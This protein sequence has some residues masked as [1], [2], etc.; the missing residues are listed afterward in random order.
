MTSVSVPELHLHNLYHTY[1]LASTSA[2][3]MAAGTALQA[4][5]MEQ[6]AVESAFRRL[7]ELS[8]PGD[9][10]KQKAVRRLREKPENPACEKPTHMAL[11]KSCAVKF[12]AGSGFAMQFQ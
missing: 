2:E 9:V 1:R 4:Q 6:Q 7:A 10:D 3:R 8:Y 5:L 11:R 12:D